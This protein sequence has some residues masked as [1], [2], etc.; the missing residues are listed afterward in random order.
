[1]YPEELDKQVLEIMKDYNP[2]DDYWPELDKCDIIS[3]LEQAW[4]LG[5]TEGR[6]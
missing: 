4:R 5:Y 3:M 6:R 1:M 2:N